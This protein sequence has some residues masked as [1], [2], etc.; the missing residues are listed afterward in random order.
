M[1]NFFNDDEVKF[2]AFLLLGLS[3]TIASLLI[4][5][6][7]TSSITDTIKFNRYKNELKEY[8]ECVH[9]INPESELD[10]QV[11]CG[12]PPSSSIML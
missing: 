1:N 3:S 8:R 10:V 9:S 5:G 2:V 7:V 12:E 11:H 6:S 4:V